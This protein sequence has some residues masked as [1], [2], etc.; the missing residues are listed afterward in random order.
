VNSCSLTG[1][2]SVLLKYWIRHGVAPLGVAAFIIMKITLF[3]ILV[4]CSSCNTAYVYCRL[5]GLAQSTGFGIRCIIARRRIPWSIIERRIQDP[6]LKNGCPT[7]FQG[8]MLL[9][10][11]RNPEFST[12]CKAP[13]YGGDSA[14]S[15]KPPLRFAIVSYYLLWSGSLLGAATAAGSEALPATAQKRALRKIF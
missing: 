8:S 12:N 13:D 7:R 4:H 15:P 14:C 9:W 1:Q 3:L 5:A 10:L 11:W 6:L 2:S